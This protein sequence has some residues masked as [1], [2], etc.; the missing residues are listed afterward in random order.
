MIIKGNIVDLIHVIYNGIVDVRLKSIE[1]DY[2]LINACS[3]IFR[4]YKDLSVNEGPLGNGAVRYG[5]DAKKIEIELMRAKV[6]LLEKTIGG[7]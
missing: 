6:D 2:V 7:G 5:N 3:S 1:K 4:I